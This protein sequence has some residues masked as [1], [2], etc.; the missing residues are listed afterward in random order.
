V[1]HLIQLCTTFLLASAGEINKMTRFAK[2]L[3]V[4]LATHR[5]D[6]DGALIGHRPCLQ[7]RAVV[8]R[9]FLI[10]MKRFGLKDDAIQ[11]YLQSQVL[12]L[13]PS[14]TSGKS[15]TS[16]SANNHQHL[17]RLRS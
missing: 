13:I 12:S 17:F 3:M 9:Q 4:H 5:M 8:V 11:N 2:E 16:T 14:S 7:L 6:L 1:D 15:S 10:G